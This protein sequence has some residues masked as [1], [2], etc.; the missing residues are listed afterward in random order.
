MNNAHIQTLSI[1]YPDIIHRLSIYPR[2]VFERPGAGQLHGAGGGAGGAAEPTA[3]S[4]AP[5]AGAAWRAGWFA[6]DQV[7]YMLDVYVYTG[8]GRCS[9]Q[10]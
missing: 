2:V 5:S 4:Q 1:D 10:V 8:Y 3:Q 6:K 9:N 7:W